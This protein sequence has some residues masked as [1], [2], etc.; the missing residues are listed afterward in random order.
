MS[1]LEKGGFDHLDV[2]AVANTAAAL[3]G[4]V[5][6]VFPDRN[7]ARIAASI[8]GML[9]SGVKA[10]RRSFRERLL[11]VACV[12]ACVAIAAA[13]CAALALS[14]VAAFNPAADDKKWAALPPLVESTINNGV[15]A[16]VAVAFLATLPRRRRRRRTLAHLHRLRSLAHVIDLHHL[17]KEPELVMPASV[18]STPDM[19]DDVGLA[20]YLSFCVE[21]LALVGKAAALCAEGDND[22]V[23]L[24]TVAEIETLTAGIARGVWQ[25]L[26][27]LQ[28]A[29][30]VYV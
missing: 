9:A 15:F 3:H 10:N 8:A 18:P 30:A 25:R 20:R 11:R 28:P 21:L 7:I 4:R 27:L 5:E 12:A 24:D 1:D 6:A 14:L 19:L 2:S 29:P 17:A 26:T 22:P 23:V 16:A 13:G